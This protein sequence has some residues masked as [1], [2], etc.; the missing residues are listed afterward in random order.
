M[1]KLWYRKTKE[2]HLEIKRVNYDK[3]NN[4]DESKKDYY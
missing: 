4:M 2:Y 1:D 3:L